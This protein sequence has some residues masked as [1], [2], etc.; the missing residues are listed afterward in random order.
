MKSILLI[1][2]FTIFI[3]TQTSAQ[4]DRQDSGR[5]QESGRIERINRNPVDKQIVDKHP[6]TIERPQKKIIERPQ[7][8][9]PKKESGVPIEGDS[10]FYCPENTAVCKVI[11]DNGYQ[12]LSYEQLAIQCFDS[13]D[14]GG[15]IL[16]IELAI[17]S[18][19]FNPS[20]YFLR[21]KI[22]FELGDYIQ[23]KRDFTTVN[24]LDPLFPDAY[25]YRGMSNLYLGEMKLAM[26][27]FR[28]ASSLG[29]AVAE[30]FL[31]KYSN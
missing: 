2:T 22:Y 26:E 13:G 19:P 23:A 14:L 29:D 15:A 17:K 24:V 21:G 31:I 8:R 10:G 18:D 7:R 4:R 27:D 28:L 11:V 25:F 6:E 12:Y 3:N 20:L 1:L 30:R 9:L 5:G 16:N